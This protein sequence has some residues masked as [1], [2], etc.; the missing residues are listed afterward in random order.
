MRIELTEPQQ[1]ALDADGT[2]TRVVDPRTNAEYL[3][4]P[5]VSGENAADVLADER[6]QAAIRRVGRRNAVGRGGV[7]RR[8]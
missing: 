5:L 3:L 6:R 7:P 4:V 2:A 8:G 1:K